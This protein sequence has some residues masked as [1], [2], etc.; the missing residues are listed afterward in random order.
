MANQSVPFSVCTILKDD[1][2]YNVIDENDASNSES[3]NVSNSSSSNSSKNEYQKATYN[4]NSGNSTDLTA[5]TG[6]SS[7]S[8]SRSR[9]NGRLFLSWLQDVDD[10]WAKI[11]EET[12]IRQRRESESLFAIQ[13]LD[14][15]WKMKELGMCDFKS[16]PLIENSFIPVVEVPMDFELLPS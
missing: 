5:L 14:W 7:G 13:K 1:E 6:N 8:G 9:Y 11:K 2:I 16:T 15:E 10:K 12:I 4:T 3:S